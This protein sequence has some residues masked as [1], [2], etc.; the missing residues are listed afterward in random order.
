MTHSSQLPV[1]AQ[2]EDVFATARTKGGV[3]YIKVVIRDEQLVPDGTESLGSS[4]EA[5][6]GKVASLLKPKTP[7]YV[8]YRLDTTNTLGSEWLL[9]A[10]VPD[11]SSVK[12]R[13]LYASTR[14]SLKKQ[15]GKSYFV[16]SDLYGTE[17]SE[18]TWE[19]Y[20][21]TQIRPTTAAPL[22]VTE[23]Q[24]HHESSQEVHTGHTK[25]YVHSVRFPLSADAINALNNLATKQHN[26]VQL[27]IDGSK[28]T[29][30]LVSAKRVNGIAGLKSELPKTEPRFTFF[31]YTHNFKGE[32]LDSIVFIYSCSDDAPVKSRMLYSSV[33]AV[34]TG[35]AEDAR[36]IVERNGKIEI[37]DVDE[38]TEEFIMESLHPAV[39][40]KKGF[41]RP[42]RPGKGGARLIRS[43]A[44]GK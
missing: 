12:D 23:M 8:L 6:F 28:E 1:S 16:S 18:F 37:A 40:V 9:V 17:V 14:D 10:Y 29:V 21:D 35:A 2:L 7:C 44:G 27:S 39:E 26:F 33:K 25:E 5:D 30:E 22:T 42:M 4:A 34:V 3:R 13:M 36:V 11:G 32:A 38:I 24:Y 31:R 15:L 19:A 43:S 41:A 20:Q